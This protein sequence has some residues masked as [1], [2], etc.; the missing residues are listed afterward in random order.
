MAPCL[1]LFLSQGPNVPLQELEESAQSGLFILAD[2]V[3]YSTS[4]YQLIVFFNSVIISLF[5]LTYKPK[6]R[7]MGER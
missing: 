1:K 2:L 6:S 7:L 3:K 4:E 5:D